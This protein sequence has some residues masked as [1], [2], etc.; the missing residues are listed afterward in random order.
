M[1]NLVGYIYR[2]VGL[3]HATLEWDTWR[4]LVSEEMSLELRRLQEIYWLNMELSA[5]EE[6][7]CPLI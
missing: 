2:A 7:P 1:L 6:D 4:D 5:S 3:I